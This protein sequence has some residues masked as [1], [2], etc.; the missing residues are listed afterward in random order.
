MGPQ[1]E[2]SVDEPVRLL[3]GNDLK[4]LA[5]YMKS[6][7]CRNVFLMLGA[8][9]STSAG[10]PD[11]RSPETGSGCNDPGLYANLARLKLPYPE[12]VFQIDFFRRN[13]VPFYTLAKELY[14]GR[15]RPTPAHSF[16]KVLHEHS[17][18]HTC[19]TQNIDTLE[20]R[21]GVPGE[22]IIE[23]HGSFAT[24]RCIDCKRPYDDE[25]IKRAVIN[26]DIPRCERCNGLVKPDIVFFG[27]ALPV[28][29]HTSIRSLRDADLLIVMGTSLTVHPFASL[30]GL[31]PKGCPRVLINLDEVGNFSRLDDLVLLGKCD[32]IVRELCRELGWEEEL[33][34]EWEATADSVEGEDRLPVSENEGEEK[35]SDELD[36]IT[37]DIEKSLA[38][39]EGTSSPGPDADKPEEKTKD[40]DNEGKDPLDKNGLEQEVPLASEGKL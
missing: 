26:S 7:S 21:A 30:V 3:E 4:A 29:F 34:R 35:V 31:V 23:A 22:K 32:D 37:K 36:R 10:I 28:Q 15:F 19:F 1:P 12:A 5:K 13:P 25:K 38:I 2:Y 40:K 39:S 33:D 20:R 18:L 14:P 17:L 9:V 8:G 24:Q 27:E 6:D 11:F 16:I